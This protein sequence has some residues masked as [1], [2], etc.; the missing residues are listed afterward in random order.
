[1]AVTLDYARPSGLKS[2]LAL[3]AA[4]PRVLLAGGTDIYPA[5]SARGLA[6]PVLDL[7]AI[8]ELRGMEMVEAGLR[9]C[10]CT[11]WSAIAAAKLPPALAA[12]QQAAAEV[13]GRQIQNAGTLGGNL[14]NASPAADGV[15]PLLTV[16]ASLELASVGG[17]RTLPLAEFIT[18]PRQTALRAG[19]IVTG[20]MIP[21]HALAGH[22]RFLKLGARK[23]LVISIAAVAVRLVEREGVVADAALAV[24]AC[25]AVARR[26]PGAEAALIGAPWAKAAERISD[27]K[28]AAGLAPLDD[29]RASAGYRNRA[30]AELLRRAVAD[31]TGG[32]A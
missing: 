20:V 16:E 25:S 22:S 14:C 28:V 29:I 9:I 30:A 24:G 32:R 27:S 6:G 5:R 3:L 15:P 1:M 26:L 18:G 23:Y 8:P 4:R 21:R 11:T 10:A 12:L 2:A 7:T 17:L 19:E 31:V 13:G